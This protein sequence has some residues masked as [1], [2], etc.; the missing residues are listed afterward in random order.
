MQDEPTG[1]DGLLRHMTSRLYERILNT[2]MDEY[3]SYKKCDNVG[4]SSGNSRCLISF[5]SK[6]RYTRCDRQ[7]SYLHP[8]TYICFAPCHKGHSDTN[9][10]LRYT[11]LTP[12]SGKEMAERLY[13]WVLSTLCYNRKQKGYAM[14]TQVFHL[15]IP[16]NRANLIDMA[17]LSPKKQPCLPK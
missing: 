7:S 5:L 16:G 15:E 12:D 10:T 8:Q 11:K 17:N 4:R 6:F 9:H 3:L 2:E 14:T 13:G 1:K